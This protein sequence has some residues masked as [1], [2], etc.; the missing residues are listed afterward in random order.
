AFVA[1]FARRLRGQSPALA[2]PL[3]WI[4]QRLSESG[5]TIEQSV[6]SENQQQAVDQVSISNSIGSLRFLSAMDWRTFVETMSVV[7]R[8]LREDPAAAYGKM[9]FATRDCYRHVVEKMARSSRR[10]EREVARHA[11]HLAQQGASKNGGDD[12]AAHVGF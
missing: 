2:L 12:R 8:T 10:S 9:D 1:E 6:Q 7:E 3:T 5:L 11:V 4:E